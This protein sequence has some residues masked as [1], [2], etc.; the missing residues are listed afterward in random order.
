MNEQSLNEKQTGDLPATRAEAR[1]GISIVWLIPLVA[2]LVGAWLA[3]KAWSETGPTITI[4]FKTAEG[5][6]AGN[7]KIN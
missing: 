6:D 1:S 7:T 5:L 3:Y 4:S 2:L